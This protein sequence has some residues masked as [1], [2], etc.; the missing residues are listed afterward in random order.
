MEERSLWL[1]LWL[2]LTKLTASKHHNGTERWCVW[3]I[4]EQ[5]QQQQQPELCKQLLQMP[6]SFLHVLL[7]TMMRVSLL[8]LVLC[9]IH[10]HT[11]THPRT[12]VYKVIQCCSNK[13]V[14][15]YLLDYRT[16]QTHT[17]G[18]K[19]L[20]PTERTECHC[21]NEY[22]AMNIAISAGMNKWVQ[23]SMEL[24]SERPS[25]GL[26]PERGSRAMS[27][28]LSSAWNTPNE[29]INWMFKYS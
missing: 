29:W 13:V 16:Y 11:L 24:T 12:Y 14:H 2:G 7:D 21:H 8:L 19:Q 25:E 9:C 22:K 6:W 20:C 4:C 5:Q 23:Y 1:F 15:K 27:V 28:Y 18:K 17:T 26:E 10:T 3:A